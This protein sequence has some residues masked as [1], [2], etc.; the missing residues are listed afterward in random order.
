LENLG[1]DGRIILKRILKK[2]DEKDPLNTVINLPFPL[3]A[4]DFLAG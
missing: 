4:V 3:N 2:L 1:E